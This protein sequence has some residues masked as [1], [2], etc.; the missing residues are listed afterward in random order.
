MTTVSISIKLT[1]AERSALR[2]LA[3][4]KNTTVSALLRTLARDDAAAHGIEWPDDR[5]KRR[6]RPK[7]S[8]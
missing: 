8:E 7:K 1:P 5:M 3:V 6:G 4:A 2:A